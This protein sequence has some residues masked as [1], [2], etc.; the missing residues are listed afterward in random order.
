MISQ[1][2]LERE[3]YLA[4]QRLERDQKYLIRV[5]LEEERQKGE[6]MGRIQLC[7][8]MLKMPPT[9]QAELLAL[10]VDDLQSRAKALEQQLGVAEA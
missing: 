1:T 2:D 8:R 4:R 3:R 10:S 7:Q 5:T 9:S 6:L